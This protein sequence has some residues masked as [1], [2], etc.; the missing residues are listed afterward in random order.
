MANMIKKKHDDKW[1]TCSECGAIVKRNNLPR[2]MKY[3]HGKITEGSEGPSEKTLPE[4]Q[5]SSRFST[6]K[7]I[8]VAIIAFVVMGAALFFL[9]GPLR[10]S[11][12]GGG[13]NIGASPKCTAVNPRGVSVSIF[14]TIS[15]NFSE[16]MNKSSVESAFSILPEVNGSFTWDDDTLIFTPSSPLENATTYTIT[17][18]DNAMNETG[19]HLETTTIWSFVT[20]GG[21][22]EHGVGSGADD[23][24]INYPSDHPQSDQSVSHPQWVL[25]ALENKPVVILAHSEGCYPCIQQQGAMQTVLEE[26]GDQVTY[27]DILTD[28]SDVRAWD[29][30]NGYYPLAGSWYIPLTV[31]LTNVEDNEGSTHVGWHSTVGA[32]GAEWITGYVEDAINYYMQTG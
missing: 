5:Q 25:G 12:E 16:P 15:V 31:I 3:V 26:Y 23:F 9:L 2:H 18:S 8:A 10:G 6:K 24:W 21:A 28:G 29:V 22:L 17:I 11:D 14:T 32:T 30:Y 20:E 27:F 13:G 4:K 7:I 1:T 19:A